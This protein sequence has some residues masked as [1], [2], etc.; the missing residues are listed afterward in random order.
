MKGAHALQVQKYLVLAEAGS[1]SWL[2]GSN[3]DLLVYTP[4]G[5]SER[6]CLDY[7]GGGKIH[8]QCGFSIPCVESWA[9]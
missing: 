1:L 9:Q 5:V 6:E 4:L 2:K 3:V 7:S 8:S